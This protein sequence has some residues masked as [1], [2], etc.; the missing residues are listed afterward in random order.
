MK[1]FHQLFKSD[2]F[3]LP[4]DYPFL[5]TKNNP[6]KIFLGEQ[7]HWRLVDE[8]LVTFMTS[9]TNCNKVF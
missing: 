1:N 2:I 5:Y 7:K 3:L 8:S 4:S 9:K 6:T